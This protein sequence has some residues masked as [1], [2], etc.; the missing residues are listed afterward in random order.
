M[1]IVRRIDGGVCWDLLVLVIV[2]GWSW[3]VS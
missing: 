3:A 1:T 2:D